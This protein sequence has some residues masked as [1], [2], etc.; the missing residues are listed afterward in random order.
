MQR[1]TALKGFSLSI[2]NHIF[3]DVM[4]DGVQIGKM[5]NGSTG[6]VDRRWQK[7]AGSKDAGR[8]MLAEKIVRVT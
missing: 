6:C 1:K 4:V 5:C 7:D 8:K 2:R 3:N